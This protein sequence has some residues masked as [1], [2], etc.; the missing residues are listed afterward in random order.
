MKILLKTFAFMAVLILSSCNKPVKQFT[1]NSNGST[2]QIALFEDSTFVEMLDLNGVSTKYLGFW[3]GDFN[4]Q[5]TLTIT[6]T[7]QDFNVL[8]NIASQHFIVDGNTLLPIDT[9]PAFRKLKDRTIYD[10]DGEYEP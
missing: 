9:L 10:K 4:D 8:T 5:D 1:L 2:R 6:V 3:E 7:R